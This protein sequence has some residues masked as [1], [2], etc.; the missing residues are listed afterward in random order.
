M[1]PSFLLLPAGFC[2]FILLATLNSAGY[3][4]GASDQAFYVPAVMA[5]L[6]PA[7]FPRDMPVIQA[8]AHLT[9]FDEVGAG[10][11][12][13]TRLPLP[14]LVLS[15]YLLTLVLLAMGGLRLG[16]VLYRGRWTRFGLLAALTLRHAITKS[17][18]NTLEG[19]FHPRQLAFALGVLALASFLRG[20]L[21]AP[22]ALVV[23]AGVLHPTTAVWLALWLA[24]ATFVADR[25]RRAAVAIA[26]AA[27]GAVVAWTLTA[28]PLAGRLV[29]IDAAWMDTLA[30]KD[31]LFPLRWPAG[32]WAVNLLYVPLIA[33]SYLWRRNL[34]ITTARETGLAAGCL[35][36]LV[37]FFGLLPFQAMRVALAIQLQPARMFWMLDF[38]ATVYVVWIAAEGPAK[39]GRH[40]TN[41]GRAKA[42][43]HD[44]AWRRAAVVA[45]VVAALSLARGLYLKFVLFPDRPVI[46][47][48]VK[49]DDW[50]RVMRWARGTD[51]GSGWLADPNHAAVYGTS[52]RVAGERD[53]LVEAVKD[54]AIGMYERNIAI[55]V[56]ERVNAVGDFGTL[57]AAH[58]RALG[59]A[60]QLDYMVSDRAVDLP[61]AF[62]SGPLAVYRLR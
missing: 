42:G 37:V 40:D 56:Q 39:A 44:T 53:V 24:V 14:A 26:G 41:E 11:A 6:D 8:Q 38:L 5:R 60:Y 21:A 23:G 50:G 27:A 28:G 52:L 10:L 46:Q 43:R 7:L 58:A 36:L 20:G 62:R 15:M 54:S 57:T 16:S 25:E 47:A 9:G 49:D 4:Y 30:S 22:A 31:Y 48:G 61:V 1:R 29:T 17:G 59:L 2:L 51:P 18:T 32:V 3:R 45:A 55:R 33:G 12:R 34:R 19:Y 35:S 13:L